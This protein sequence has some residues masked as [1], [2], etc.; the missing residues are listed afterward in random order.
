MVKKIPAWTRYVKRNDITP[1][2]S[3]RLRSIGARMST[4]RPAL[5]RRFS[6]AR[7]SASVTPPAKTIQITGESP[8][9][10]GASGFGWT[11]PQAGFQDPRTIKLSPSADGIVPPRSRRTPSSAGLSFIRRASMRITRTMIT[12]PANTHRQDA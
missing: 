8:N 3:C 12:S 2:R 4:P 10:V 11:R 5:T 7:K 1:L 6:Q 9:T